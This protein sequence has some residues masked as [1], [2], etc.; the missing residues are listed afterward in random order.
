MSSIR[1]SVQVMELLA[2][3][4][5]LGVRA[6]AT[7]LALPLSSVHRLLYD[8]EEEG[9]AER[10]Q[11]GD[12]ELSFRL[13]EIAGVQLER[14]E[15]PRLCRPFAERIAQATRETVN[16][17]ALSGLHGV[18]VDK[19]RGNDGPQLDLRIGAR[20]FLYC[21]GAGKA[22]LAYMSEGEQQAVLDGQFAALTPKTITDAAVLRAELDRIRAR[23]YSIDD[24][25]VVMGV[26]CVSVPILD[27]NARPTGAISITGTS[28]KQAGP[29]VLPLVDMLN[30]ACG[31]ISRRLGYRGVWP[32]VGGPGDIRLRA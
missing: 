28:P 8:L 14:I 24:Q 26:Y 29:E 18:C 5:P 13:L 2:R 9:M 16:I 1:R 17:N 21:G 15:L 4:S 30:D 3:K 20:G 19:V 7:Q 6:I 12:W 31:Q 22:M 23:G 10:T 27:G 11:A 25:E 32:L